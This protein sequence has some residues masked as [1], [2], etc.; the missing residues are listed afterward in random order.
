[1]AGNRE[2]WEDS[3]MVNSLQRAD[4]ARGAGDTGTEPVIN[5]RRSSSQPERRERRDGLGIFS[6]NSVPDT[7]GD[8]LLEILQLAL[9]SSNKPSHMG[10][11]QWLAYGDIDSDR[12]KR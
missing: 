1:M 4:Q 6:E 7:T 3:G 10:P 11:L 8:V 12:R 2:R 5:S 9:G